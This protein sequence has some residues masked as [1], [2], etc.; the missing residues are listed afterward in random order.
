MMDTIIVFRVEDEHIGVDINKVHEVTESQN[1]VV[2]PKSPKFI[3]GLVNIRGDVIPV[4]SLKRRLDIGG[5]D[6]GNLL[7]VVEDKGR[8]VGIKVDELFGTKRIDQTRINR[9][10]EFLS[11]KKEKDF[12]VGVYEGEE[13]PILILDLEKTL[14]QED[15]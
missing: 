9:R 15:T 4:L 1:P 8:S 11:T 5:D 7:L 14:S 10:S 6:T 12:F 3:L 2:V 13:Q